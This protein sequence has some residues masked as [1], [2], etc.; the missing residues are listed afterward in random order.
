MD[1]CPSH[2]EVSTNKGAHI[3]DFISNILT[4]II[5][6]LRND[7]GIHA[8][9]R[10]SQRCILKDHCFQRNVTGSLADTQQRTVNC[11]CTVE[12][13]CG[14]ICNGFIEVIMAV[15]LQ[16]LTGDIGVMLQTVDDTG[17]ASGHSC[18]R[19]RHAVTHGITGTDLNGNTGLT[20][21]LLQFIDKRNHKT[22][23]ISAGNILQMAARLDAHI[24]CIG[25]SSQVI[26]KNLLP[27]HLHLFEDVVVAAADQDTGLLNTH[28][29]N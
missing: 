23:K 6:D 22:V 1:T 17:D 19:I 27:V 10:T 14:C 2:V 12:P 20:G 13:C 15:P 11:R 5:G 3:G 9:Q 8:V 7:R 16:L 4:E 26:V 28:I 29:L 24:Q 18:F 21:E 25:N